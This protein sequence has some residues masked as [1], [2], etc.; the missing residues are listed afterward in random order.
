MDIKIYHNKRCSKSNAAM[1]AL[2]NQ[3]IDFTIVN[4]LENPPS[5]QE[6]KN[7]LQML[8]LKPLEL[9]RTNEEVFKEK[10]KGKNLA[11]EEL[12]V[13]MHENPILIQRPII[14]KG[15]KAVIARSEEA[16]D[17]II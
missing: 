4:Y 8:E 11:D 16:I 7:I 13:A 9:M 12:I 3:N 10:V 2:E 17:N 15:N 6:L 1:K 5:V 14:I